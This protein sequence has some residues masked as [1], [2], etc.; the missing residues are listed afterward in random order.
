MCV[1]RSSVEGGKR[2]FLCDEPGC[3]NRSPY[4]TALNCQV[5]T[6]KRIAA[7]FGFETIVAVPARWNM[8]HAVY[9]HQCAECFA[10]KVKEVKDDTTNG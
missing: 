6:M 8:K 2:Y 3:F 5:P 9:E 1:M 4:F 7:D 10:K